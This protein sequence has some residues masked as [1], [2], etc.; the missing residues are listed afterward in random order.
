MY[1]CSTFTPESNNSKKVY[2]NL[3]RC[4]AVYV[5]AVSGGGSRVLATLGLNLRAALTFIDHGLNKQWCKNKKGYLQ[6]D[7]I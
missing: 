1:P 7:S 5:T 4:T 3:F 2:L 6:R